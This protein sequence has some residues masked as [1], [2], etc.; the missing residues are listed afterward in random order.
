MVVSPLS[1]TVPV[2]VE[3]VVAPVCEKFP[4]MVKAPAPVMS[5]VA[6]ISQ[7]LVLMV[8]VLEFPPIVTEPVLVPVAMFT[9]LLLLVFKEIVPPE[10]VAPAV[11][12]K[13][14]SALMVPM[15][16]MLPVASISQSEE[17]MATVA[18]LLPKVVTPVESRVVNDPAPPEI[19]APVMAPEEEI[20]IEGVFKKFL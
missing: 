14:P 15:L 20:T 7:S 19:E 3:K 16:D 5:P 11:P 13:S 18:E 9:A 10:I 17:L 2:P 1:E 8:S 12:V 6:L 4:S